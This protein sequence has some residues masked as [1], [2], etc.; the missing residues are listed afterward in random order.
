MDELNAVILKLA[1]GSAALDAGDIAVL[2]RACRDYPASG[3]PAALLV[4]YAGAALGN[5][6]RRAL[7]QRV[8]L[9]SGDS[10]RLIEA[11]DPS[12][13]G[14]D[15]F[16]PPEPIMKKPATEN[17][18][19]TFLETYGHRTDEEDAL[20]ERMIFNPV[21]D[22]SQTL[23]RNSADTPRPTAA[24]GSQESLIDAFLASNPVEEAAPKP[25]PAESDDTRSKRPAKPQQAPSEGLLSESLAKI[26]IKQGRYERAYEIISNLNL[27]YPEKSIYFAD[28]L[29]FL[30]KLMINQ[31]H[32]QGGQEVQN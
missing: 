11:I 6:E 8:A 3:V 7:Q 10:R 16:Y 4:R 5:D 31:R 32:A 19:D 26:F 23:A 12:G 21:P 27:N 22:Y 15:N 28:Q 20:L 24:P 14:F 18:I 30:R 17:A 2:R 25:S 29:R 9:L 1:D 13:Q